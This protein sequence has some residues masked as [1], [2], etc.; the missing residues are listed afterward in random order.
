MK[1]W[2]TRNKMIVGIVL[3]AV[4]GCHSPG[5]KSET[6]SLVSVDST[7]PAAPTENQ[8]HS[9]RSVVVKTHLRDTTLIGGSF[10]LFLRPDQER[11]TE[12]IEHDPDGGIGD[13]DS[14]FGVGINNTMDSV[15]KNDK[16]KNVKVLISTKR[17][18]LIEDCNLLVII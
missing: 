5:K 14:D 4:T 16:Y 9:E 12:S 8:P 15:S 17:F 1:T 13:G 7:E 11:F 10:I 18:I 3:F 6:V 2:F